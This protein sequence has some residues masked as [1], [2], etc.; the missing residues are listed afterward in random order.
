LLA[1]VATQ[2]DWQTAEQRVQ[3]GHEGW[4][5]AAVGVLV[6]ALLVGAVRW[7]RLLESAAV[8]TRFR[9][10]LRAFAI[11]VF[12]NNFLPT[13][14]GGD[15]ARGWI[16]GKS[17]PRLVR[18][19]TSVAVDRA[20]NLACLVLVGWIALAID[21]SAAP[22][23][24]VV[25]LLVA[26]AAGGAAVVVLGVA[27]AGAGRFS[28]RFPERVRAWA[29][30]AR[31]A[32]GS[33]RRDRGLLG[34]I[35]ALG[36]GY[37]GLIVTSNWMLAKSIGLDLPFA[38]VAVTVPLVL[39]ATVIP[40]SIA[41][42]GVREGTF[43]V[44]LG[45]AGVATTDA[46]LL[47]LLTVVALALSSLPGA[48]ALLLRGK[49]AEDAREAVEELAEGHEPHDLGVAAKRYSQ[50]RPQLETGKPTDRAR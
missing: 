10:T 15:A 29:V 39:L 19:L 16:V 3:S 23:S 40:I 35:L 7:H 8:P 26:T 17:G 47:S 50:P 45:E 24:L 4:F 38:L 11:G 46:T 36:L 1:V 44:L 30:Q 43:A 14:F 42:F 5:A 27:A 49:S 28:N 12:S 31:A 9:E 13:G 21:P 32:L 20:T 6:F 34:W 18:S 25:A 33:Y 48:A 37:Q 22:S 2:V 41:G